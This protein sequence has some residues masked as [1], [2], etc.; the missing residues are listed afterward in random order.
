MIY[1]EALKDLAVAMQISCLSKTSLMREGGYL[2]IVNDKIGRFMYNF[3]ETLSAAMTFGIA[4][5]MTSQTI[6]LAHTWQ[7][8]V[9][10][11]ILATPVITRGIAYFYSKQSF[12]KTDLLDLYLGQLINLANI[13][14]SAVLLIIIRPSVSAGES[15]FGALFLGINIGATYYLNSS[16]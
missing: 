13:V 2:S 11:S 15:I 16:F 14:S 10:A 3:F 6:R 7:K 4:C 5:S 12:D 1:T 9:L 8:V